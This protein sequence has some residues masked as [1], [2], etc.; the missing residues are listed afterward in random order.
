M[1]VINHRTAQF[2]EYPARIQV[3]LIPTDTLSGTFF[4]SID[5]PNTNK[6]RNYRLDVNNVPW[7][8]EYTLQ[9][10]NVEVSKH[11]SH[12]VAPNHTN[13]HPGHPAPKR[14]RDAL[15]CHPPESPN[16]C[17]YAESRPTNKLVCEI[18]V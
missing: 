10:I 18:H 12:A 13:Y 11:Q 6:V 17:L 14:Q 3:N 1:S 16:Y 15:Q 7:D 2:G 5:R 4:W 9:A 8:I